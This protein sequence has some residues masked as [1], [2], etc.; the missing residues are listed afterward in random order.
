MNEA[1]VERFAKSLYE[2]IVKEN[3]ELYKDMYQNI[4]IDSHTD[5]SG[6]GIIN[7][8][9]ELSDEQRVILFELIEQ[10]MIDTVST[11]LGIIDGHVTQADDSIEPKLF[12]NSQDTEGDL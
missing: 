1:V 4:E 5:E 6:K 8:Y 3:L 10:T 9:N 11:V 7:F 2:S 12:L